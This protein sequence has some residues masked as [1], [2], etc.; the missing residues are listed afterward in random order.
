MFEILR[1]CSESIF[2][3]IK[4]KI[5]TTKGLNPLP[6]SQVLVQL[7]SVEARGPI[8]RYNLELNTYLLRYMII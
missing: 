1:V 4:Y 8:I 5:W 2:T 3:F 6:A 7:I